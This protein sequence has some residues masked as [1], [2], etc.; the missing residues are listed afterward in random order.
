MRAYEVACVECGGRIKGERDDGPRR[1]T[2]VSAQCGCGA[3]NYINLAATPPV[4]GHMILIRGDSDSGHLNPDGTYHIE[5]YR[6]GSQ[7]TA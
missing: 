1:L 3:W 7:G 5:R 4:A 2:I 6:V